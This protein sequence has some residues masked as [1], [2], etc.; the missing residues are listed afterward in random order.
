MPH[1]LSH[2]CLV[3]VWSNRLFLL[4]FVL[5]PVHASN[6]A[7]LTED[8]ARVFRSPSSRLT[9]LTP[10]LP[11]LGH[12]ASFRRR[13]EGERREACGRLEANHGLPLLSPVT[14]LSFPRCSRFFVILSHILV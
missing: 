6:L 10:H 14:L 2:F 1:V 8:S 5:H 4:P 12:S 11:F 3:H 13:E 7:R 9:H